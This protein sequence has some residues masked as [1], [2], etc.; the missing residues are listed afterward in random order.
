MRTL[1]TVAYLLLTGYITAFF[2]E[3]SFWAG[4][5]AWDILW[6][7]PYTWL[8]YTFITWL[9]LC[10]VR[11]FRARTLWALFLA[12]ALYGWLLKGVIVQTT[13]DDFPLNI[14]FTALAWHAPF[15]ILLGW[16]ALPR[17]MAEASWL[18]W[19]ATAGFGL[20]LGLWSIG[21]WV[22]APV[23]PVGVV[24]LY[25]TAFTLL[26]MGAYVARSRLDGAL[27]EAQWYS[28]GA[29]YVA[30]ALLLVY[31]IFVTIPAQPV[32]L[33]ILPPLLG[34]TLLSLQHNRRI[35]NAFLGEEPTRQ[36][37]PITLAPITVAQSL[38]LLLIPLI[39]TAIYAI[40]A[41]LG[42]VLPTLQLAYFVLMPLGFALF[43]ISLY[44]V[45]RR[46]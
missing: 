32:A 25:N 26:L 7:F 11:Y 41:A 43:G 5:P 44:Q 23:A 39:A 21:W 38:P 37:T 15:S 16:Y 9:F 33:Y 31:A 36:S 28:R 8:L 17:W 40:A 45:W 6:G 34:V 18:V 14:S 19:Q 30:L 35:E 12:G 3:W 46:K 42:L 4:R 20:F 2:S 29:V 1:R 22:E 10:A 27:S 13:Y 24:F